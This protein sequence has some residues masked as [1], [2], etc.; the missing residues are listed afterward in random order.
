MAAP[1]AERKASVAEEAWKEVVPAF[2]ALEK[3][4]TKSEWLAGPQFSV[5]DLNVAAALFRALTL[6]L[7]KWPKLDAWLHKCWDRP[8]AKKAKAMRETK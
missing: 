7:K 5:A 1:E 3:A 4:L 6:D 2:D 8:A